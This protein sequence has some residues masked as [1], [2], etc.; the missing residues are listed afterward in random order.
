MKLLGQLLVWGSLT[1]G[2]LA[3]ATGYI[4]SLEAEDEILIG[5]TM[6]AP[7]G[8]IDR[9]DDEI[10]IDLTLAASAGRT[11]QSEDDA[12]PMAKKDQKITAGLLAELRRAGV[13]NIRV[14]E[15]NVRRW[16]GKWFFLVSLAGLLL[17]AF[18]TRTGERPKS[19]SRTAESRADSPQHTLTSM[20]IA[21]DELKTELAGMPD[22]SRQLDAIVRRVGEV[23]KTHVP[24]FVEA[25][26]ELISTLGLAS[27]AALMD[28][29]AAAERKLNRAWSAAVDKADEEAFACLDQAASLLE[30]AEE[31]LG[32]PDKARTTSHGVNR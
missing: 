18:V 16:R 13:R 8:K 7:A 1:V 4:A 3:A 14:K 30:A 17:G 31:K 29:F 23:Q 10:L 27:F 6:A 22:R 9:V 26:A 11:V 21:I 12:K 25:R 2:A 20:R 24:A 15:F 19:V 28:S 32:A 5:L